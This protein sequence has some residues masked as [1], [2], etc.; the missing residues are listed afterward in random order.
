MDKYVNLTTLETAYPIGDKVYLKHDPEQKEYEVTGII[1]APNSV[2]FEICAG[3]VNIQAHEYEISK[4][5]DEA[6]VLNYD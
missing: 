4:L 1:F 6:K 2:V 5:K 3:E